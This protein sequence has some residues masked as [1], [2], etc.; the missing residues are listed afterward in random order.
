MLGA[1]REPDPETNPGVSLG[2]AISTLAHAGRDKLTFLRRRRDRQLRRVGRAAHRGEHRQAR[3][4]DRPGRPRAPRRRRRYGPD[5]AFVRISLAGSDGGTPRRAGRRAGG[6]RPS[7]HPDRADRPDRPRRRVR[8]LGGRDAI[9]IAG[10]RSSASIRSTS[11]TS[12]RPRSGPATCSTAPAATARATDGA[13]RVE[14]IASGDGLA[15]YGD[16]ALRLTSGDGDVVGELRGTS[17]GAVPM[18]T[19]ASRRSSRRRPA[20]DEAIA[21]IRTPCATGPAARRRPATGRASSTRPASSTR[22]ARRP[23]G[24]SS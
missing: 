23:A 8:P 4:R 10:C 9:A 22:A 5:R 6:S 24:S 2:L 20:R 15:L 21:R 1:C 16:A 12:R 11:R 7:G 17:P 13:R 18:R 3:R 14:P 19:S